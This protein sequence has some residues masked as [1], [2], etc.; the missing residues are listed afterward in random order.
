MKAAVIGGGFIGNEHV[1]ALR[2]LGDVEV[3]ALCDAYNSREKADRLN[4]RFAYSDFRKMMEELELDV[5]HIC[6]PNHTHYEIARH[7]IKKGIHVVCEKPFT[8]TAEEAEELVRLAKEK[9]VHGTVNFHNRFYPAA[10]QMR[11]MVSEGEIGRVISVHGTYIQDWLLYETDYSW[12]VEE[13]LGGK[14]RAV[15]DIGSHWLDLAQFVTGQDIKKVCAVFNTIYP[16]RKKGTAIGESFAKAGQGELEEVE[17]TTEDEAAI[18]VELEN[19][20]IGS[21]FISQVFAGKKNTTEL[22]VAG[23]C[24]SLDWNSEQLGELGIGHRDG[25]NE[26]LTKDPSLMCENAAAAIGFPGGHV[27]GFPDAIKQGF[28]QFYDSLSKEGDFQYA[29]FQDGLEEI[30]LCDAILKSA[31]TK[32]WVEVEPPDHA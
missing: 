18:L 16:V 5:V 14:I 13:R 4:I 30:R 24:A 7:A 15:A 19:G 31:Q 20:A 3:V 1:E 23:T 25:P 6:T 10:I 17:V 8:S 26:V 21:V 32:Q 27:E 2:R 29:T 9:G 28:R 11:H 22:L 12:R